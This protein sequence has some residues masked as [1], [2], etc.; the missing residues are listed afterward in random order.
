MSIIFD[1]TPELRIELP[2]FAARMARMD[3]V[4][5]LTV[6]GRRFTA[7]AGNR[8]RPASLVRVRRVTLATG[9]TS[10]IPEFN[11]LIAQIS[12]RNPSSW[13]LLAI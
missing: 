2:I 12:A 11:H 6:P 4:R 10:E 8:H 7:G 3:E 5:P 13:P 9:R 1:H